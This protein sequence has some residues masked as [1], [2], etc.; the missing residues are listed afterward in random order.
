MKVRTGRVP[1]ITAVANEI[2]TLNN[3]IYDWNIV[4][5]IYWICHAR[6]IAILNII[7]RRITTQAGKMTIF[8]I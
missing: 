3:L 4:P 2:S 8:D 7:W 6:R 5:I 1:G